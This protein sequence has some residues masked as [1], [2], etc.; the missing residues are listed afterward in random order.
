MRTEDQPRPTDDSEGCVSVFTHL[1]K[2]ANY[3]RRN[4]TSSIK[5]IWER[6]ITCFF[7]LILFLKSEIPPDREAVARW[8][9][10]C[11]LW[12]ARCSQRSVSWS[13]NTLHFTPDVHDLMSAPQKALCSFILLF[14]LDLR[15]APGARD[16]AGTGLGR[17]GN[18]PGMPRGQA[19]DASGT[20][21][22]HGGDGLGL[23]CCPHVSRSQGRSTGIVTCHQPAFLAARGLSLR[24]HMPHNPALSQGRPGP[25]QRAHTC[26]QT[27]LG[28]QRACSTQR[29]NAK[30]PE[31]RNY[32]QRKTAGPIQMQTAK[33]IFKKLKENDCPS[34][35]LWCGETSFKRKSK[36]KL[37]LGKPKVREFVANRCTGKP[38]S[39]RRKMI[40]DKC[41]ER[42][43][44]MNN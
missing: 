44:W 4:D 41:E 11:G 39:A 20:V 16:A 6:N 23:L 27:G 25:L 28:A 14:F 21:W 5:I 40:L 26:L 24:G 18:G 37:F 9:T 22:G 31:T 2:H 33:D 3:H 30:K 35:S 34:A 17:R 13:A 43:E 36:A 10:D 7:V 38:A 19:R 32:T 8:H 12:R 42:N 1:C 29:D 15:A